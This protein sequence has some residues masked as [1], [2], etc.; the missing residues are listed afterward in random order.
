MISPLGTDNIANP[1]ITYSFHNP[2]PPFS[3]DN[4]NQVTDS[5][6]SLSCMLTNIQSIRNKV[7][8]FQQL[9]HLHKLVVI[10]VTES[11][12]DSM[13]SDVEISLAGYSFYHGIEFY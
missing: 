1:M 6:Y 12:C 4:S 9:I 2:P 11:W 5:K 10:G 7:A 8:E 3:F 13:I